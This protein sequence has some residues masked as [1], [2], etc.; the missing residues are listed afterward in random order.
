MAR[1]LIIEDNPVNMKLAAF[2]LQNAGYEVLQAV[3]AE[4][5]LQVA[6]IELPDLILMDMQLPGIDGMT[7]TRQ[8]KA[9]AA[10]AHIKIVALTA[11]AM[12]GDEDRFRAAGCDAY[13]AKPIRYQAFLSLVDS[14]LKA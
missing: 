1:V 10:T 9:A 12:S 7:A 3:D 14:I 5:G 11:F 2:L 4:I 13:M 8:L 6:R